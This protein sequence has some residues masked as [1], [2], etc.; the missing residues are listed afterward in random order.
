MHTHETH[1]RNETFESSV[2]GFINDIEDHIR[3]Q[4]ATCEIK[5]RILKIHEKAMYGKF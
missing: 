2:E 1:Q 4:E 5:V 3:I